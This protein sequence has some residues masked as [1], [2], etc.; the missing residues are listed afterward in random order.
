VRNAL[1]A[2]LDLIGER[3]MEAYG[4]RLRRAGTASE[5]VAL[6]REIYVDDLEQGY[7]TVLGE[8]VSAGVADA[9]LGREV[10]ARIEPWIALATEKVQ[11][12]LAGSPLLALV[13]PRDLAY[14]LV[15]LVFGVDLLSHLQRAPERA[16]SLLALAGRLA[17]LAD[18]TLTP[19]NKEPT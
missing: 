17:A 8:M 3:R 2:G 18:L 12:L 10:A 7:V 13:A 4:E 11:Q 14:G 1:L 16:E 5:L 19:A 9:D 6:V 15:G